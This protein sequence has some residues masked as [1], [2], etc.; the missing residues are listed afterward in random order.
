VMTRIDKVAAGDYQA[1]L[2]ALAGMKRLGLAAHAGVLLS[3]EVMVPSSCQGIVGVTVRAD[4]TE[5]LEMLSAIEDPAARAVA[6]AE[7]ALLGMLDGSCATPI[8]GYARLR[9]DGQL[10]MTGLIAR[11]D[12]SFL[13]RRELEGA[14]ADAERIG[15]AL[16]ESLRADAPADLFA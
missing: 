11:A 8:G 2:L 6:T 13:L 15:I 12:G 5:L 9:A 10:A 14:P 7:R 16:G 3:P 1:S 4:D